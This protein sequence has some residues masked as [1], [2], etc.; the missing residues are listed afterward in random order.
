VQKRLEIYNFTQKKMDLERRKI[1]FVQ[2]FL[3]LQN[4]EIICGLENLLRK[5][6]IELLEKKIAPMSIEQLNHEIDQSMLD[7]ENGRVTSAMDLK[8]KV[9]RWS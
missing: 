3:R 7:S 4:E 2:E 5:K 9:K 6:K 8:E 1:A